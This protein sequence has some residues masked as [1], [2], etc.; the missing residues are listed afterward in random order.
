[1]GLGF[2]CGGR[3]RAFACVCL[4]GSLVGRC[5]SRGLVI[6]EEVWVGVWWIGVRFVGGG[7]VGFVLVMLVVLMMGWCW[8]VSSELV[9]CGGSQGWFGGF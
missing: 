1:M 9:G 7:E 4:V 2:A 6:W 8:F 3:R 5:G